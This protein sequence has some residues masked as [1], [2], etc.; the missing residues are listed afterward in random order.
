MFI[1]WPAVTHNLSWMSLCQSLGLTTTIV[2]LSGTRR[3]VRGPG[4][5]FPQSLE[6]ALDEDERSERDR[7]IAK[8]AQIAEQD[9]PDVVQTFGLDPASYLYLEAKDRIPKNHRPVW[10][11]QARGGPEIE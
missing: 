8:L 5:V 9:R 11:V 6:P 7:L 2:H 10:V 4:G 3:V 1:G